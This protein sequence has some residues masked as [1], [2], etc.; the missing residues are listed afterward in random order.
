MCI[1]C[2]SPGLLIGLLCCHAPA[3]VLAFSA[4]YTPELLEDLE[5][6]MKRPQRVMLC[7][8][9]TSLEGVRQ[10]YVLV[11]PVSGAEG[12]SEQGEQGAGEDDVDAVFALK[13]EALLK[14][15]SSLSFHQVRRGGGGRAVPPTISPLAACDTITLSPLTHVQAAVFLN[16]KP[17]AEWLAARLTAE[18]FPSAYLS[19]GDRPQEER[20]Q[21]MGAVRAFKLRVG[22]HADH[23][24]VLLASAHVFPPLVSSPLILPT[25]TP[26]LQ[27]MVSTDVMA[28]GVDLDRVNVV[29]NL[30]L[31]RDSATYVHR[32][33]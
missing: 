26:A 11:P 16:R 7:S 32:C 14:L 25:L 8:E 22:P 6:L 24:A 31:P 4:T 17:Q 12:S 3:Q 2:A 13:V 28:R 27:V 5:P 1:T 30:D 19:G 20:M 9:T 23:G 33:V 18:G 29:A 10:F 21:A 15:L